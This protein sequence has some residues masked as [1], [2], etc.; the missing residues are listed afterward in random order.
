MKN[1]PVSSWEEKRD[2][3]FVWP[4]RA[5]FG[6]GLSMA[7]LRLL[8]ITLVIAALSILSHG[9]PTAGAAEI[10]SWSTYSDQNCGIEF[11]YPALYQFN[12]SGAKDS[13]AL[14][15]LMGLK[16]ARQTRWLLS[17]NVTEMS[18]VY[19]QTMVESGLEVSPSSFALYLAALHC[20]ADGPEGSTY[21]ADGEIRSTFKTAQG[22]QAYEI[23][24]TEV[25]ESFARKRIDKRPRGPIFALDM[26]NDETVWIL[27]A[28]GSSTHL[29]AL[30]AILNSLR[31]WGKARRELPQMVEL[32]RFSPSGQPFNIRVTPKRFDG[33]RSGPPRPP[34]SMLLLDPRGRRLGVDSATNA[35]YAEVPAIT[36]SGWGESGVGL[37]EPTEGRYQLEIT[38]TDASIPYEVAVQALDQNGKL[39]SAAR[40]G[41]TAEPGAI[42]RYELVYSKTSTPA[43]TLS[44]M[45]DFSE[46]TVLLS[47]DGSGGSELLLSDP[48]GRRTGLDPVKNVEREIPRSSYLAEGPQ[49]RTMVLHIRQPMDGWY[50][51]QV[52]GS[53]TGSYSLDIRARDTSGTAAIRPEFR[54]VPTDREK[55]HRYRME[56]QTNGKTPLKV[57]GGFDG[58]G[59]K[60]REINSFLTYANPT[61]PELRLQA[62]VT[63]FPL[64]IF[65]G[66]SIQ[67]T[68][69]NAMLNG[70]NISGRF[71]PAPD[72]YEFVWI[73]LKAGANTLS[74]GVE[75]I[76]GSG[77]KAKDTDEFVFVVE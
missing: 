48:Q 70:S 76:T 67:P 1:D 24:M 60:P 29:E 32:R 27:L 12:P 36:Y 25:D 44:E 77:Q 38:A 35:L 72:Q 10:A 63:R 65:Y 20:Q 64:L 59:E 26:S 62:E 55:V 30:K 54:S 2:S 37:R 31:V 22:L 68:T 21:C 9:T 7:A 28:E 18:Q 53:G 73:P 34:T 3:E 57:G 75:G 47:G 4:T 23:H 66:P 15:V 39:W 71:T 43:V 49:P 14:S 13:C 69:F 41:R 40:T 33:P 45:K 74:L 8:F 52:S 42:D 56:Y 6:T 19:R 58:G 11:K 51:L 46:I 61:G 50:L 5:E 17:L 16:E